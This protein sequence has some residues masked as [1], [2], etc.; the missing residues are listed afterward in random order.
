MRHP[1]YVLNGSNLNMLGMREPALYGT[2]TLAEIEQRTRELAESLGLA[3]DFRQTNHEGVL[4]DWIQ[5]AACSEA[6][7]VI[8]PAGFSFRCVPLL[9]ALKLVRK[10][11][12]EVH[13]TNIHQR[14]APYTHSLVSQAA[15]GVICGLGVTGYPVAVRAVAELLTTAAAMPETV[16]VTSGQGRTGD[17]VGRGARVSARVGAWHAHEHFA[18]RLALPGFRRA[19]RW[20]AIEGG[21]GFFVMYEL[22]DH[23]VLA[24][25]AYVARLNAPSPWST[26]MMPLHRGMVRCQCK[27]LQ[28]HG[29]VTARHALTIRLSA[30]QERRKRCNAHCSNWQ[31][32]RHSSLASVGLHLL[33]HEPPALE[34]TTEQKIRGNADRAADSVIVACGYDLGALRRLEADELA[35]AELQALGAAPSTERRFY[36]LAYCAT[37]SDVQYVF[38]YLFFSHR[39]RHETTLI[40][41][42]AMLGLVAAGTAA[43]AKDIQERVI[44]FG[45]LNNAD[46]PTSTG[47]K[48]FAEIVAAKS[49]GKITV[50]EYPAASWATNCSSSR[51][52]AGGVQEM[53]VASTTSLAGIVKEF[54]L[55]D[56]PF[57]FSNSNQADAMVDGPLGK[58]LS[59]R[60]ADKGVVILGFFDLGARNVTN[61]KR[62][63]T[64]AED[65]DGL[66]LRVI[67]PGFLETFS[68]FKANPVP[69]PFAELY[70]AL[71]SKAVDGQENPYAVIL[72]NKF[73]EVNKYVSATNHVYATN[74]VQISKMFWQK[75][76]PAE[77]KLLQDAAIEAQTISAWSAARPPARR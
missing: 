36:G 31:H 53:L 27:V 75:L 7:L 9:D 30:L 77:Q 55:F 49:G 16:H 62:P 37:P 74:P 29:A 68:T 46:H 8:N 58:M 65:L 15:T 33:R 38:R 73:F 52:C 17:V 54:G 25:P 57:L 48:K 26:R 12:I 47:V 19:S 40:K 59:A 34:A 72:S 20:T 42:T 64:K 4:V 24:S 2:T 5:E 56:F 35:V 69:M 1:L 45:H 18:E 67:E 51:R 70:N 23:S 3:C 41:L 22:E 10:P 76:S 50:K 11:V 28:S 43:L 63:I 32:Q 71:E 6:A 21:D 39:R 13:L 14:P 61:S 44:K 60:L 66:K